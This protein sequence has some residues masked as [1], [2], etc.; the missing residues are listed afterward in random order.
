MSEHVTVP[1]L[2]RAT[3]ETQEWI[4]ELRD[5]GPFESA[6]Q[7]YTYL[8][9]VLHALRDRLTVEEAA[10]SASQMPMLV[11]GFYYEGWRPAL[12]PNDFITAKELYARVE[13]SLRSGPAP[14][15]VPVAEGTRAVLELLGARVDPGQ[16]EHVRDQMPAEIVDEVFAGIARS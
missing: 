9:A 4:N 16:M 7:A 11:R 6:E 2:G 10:H 12:A 1:Q 5:R 14:S 15:G 8:R 13:Q 3:Q